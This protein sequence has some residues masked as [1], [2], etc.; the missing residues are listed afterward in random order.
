MSKTT[1]WKCSHCQYLLEAD[2]PPE[3]CPSC[4]NK[5][6][7]TDATC[8]TPECGGEDNIDPKLFEKDKENLS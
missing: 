1:K 4:H 7:F 2:K 3:E 5:C 8:Y 6:A